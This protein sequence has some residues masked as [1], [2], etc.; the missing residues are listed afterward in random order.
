MSQAKRFLIM[1]RRPPYGSAH[2]REALDAALT[3]AVFEQPVAML[4]LDDGVYQ[5][6]KDQDS[7]AI[8]QKNLAAT[9]GALP[10][11]DID[12]IYVCARALRERGLDPQQ[13]VAAVEPLEAGDIA[14]LIR[15]HDLVLS[16]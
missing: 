1:S 8:A 12:R 10:L 11:Y 13:L 16:F 14:D 9:L 4:F 2:A 3:T 5:L 7:A 15:Q 6:L